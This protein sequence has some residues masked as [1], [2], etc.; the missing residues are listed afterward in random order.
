MSSRQVS[1]PHLLH[2][3]SRLPLPRRRAAALLAAELVAEATRMGG[4]GG[5]WGGLVSRCHME[6][7][8]SCAFP[9]FA[10]ARPRSRAAKG[11][12]RSEGGNAAPRRRTCKS[13]AKACPFVTL[14]LA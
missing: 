3:W 8:G 2:C 11:F 12:G 13:Q 14:S 1:A 10:M 6:S 4:S 9:C 5:H 7:C